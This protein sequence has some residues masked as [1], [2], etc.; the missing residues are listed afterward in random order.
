MI[1][2]WMLILA[3]VIFPLYVAGEIK[4]FIRRRQQKALEKARVRNRA[5]TDATVLLCELEP[6]P[7]DVVWLEKVVHKEGRA[8][9]NSLSIMMDGT[10]VVTL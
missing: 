1:Y 7:Y 9:G 8:D 6:A 2:N 5:Y 4:L 10:R 3:A